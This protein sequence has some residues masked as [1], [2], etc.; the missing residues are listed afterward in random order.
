M[1]IGTAIG[2]R[3]CRAWARAERVARGAVR[4][5]VGRGRCPGAG[6][7]HGMQEPGERVEWRSPGRGGRGVE[8]LACGGVGQAGPGIVGRRS[9]AP[10][11]WGVVSG[12]GRAR[13]SAEGRGTSDRSGAQGGARGAARAPERRTGVT[14]G[15]GDGAA[16]RAGWGCSGA[17]ERGGRASR[18]WQGGAAPARTGGAA[19]RGCGPVGRYAHRG[20][21]SDGGARAGEAR[22]RLRF[23][24]RPA[25]AT[26][27]PNR[28]PAPPGTAAPGA[29]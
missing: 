18:A 8:R 24:C 5:H 20:V 27:S 1:G 4:R 6:A 14:P 23:R 21:R 13:T 7:G 19:G 10:G 3:R 26:P 11:A 29:W 16:R 12:V 25:R 15:A 28:C 22:G 17:R 2:V 9:G